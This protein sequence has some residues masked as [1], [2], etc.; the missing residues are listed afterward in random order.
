MQD[1]IGG[2]SA[3]HVAR[4][5]ISGVV[6]DNA[7]LLKRLDEI[8]KSNRAQALIVRLESPGGTS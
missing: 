1:P 2:R 3:N 4:V 6:T 7:D 5:T 8:R